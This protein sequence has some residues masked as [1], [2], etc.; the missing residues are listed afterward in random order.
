MLART[1]AALAIVAAAEAFSTPA[2]SGL[3]MSS[4]A[5]R[6]QVVQAGAAAAAVTPFIGSQPAAAKVQGPTDEFAPV[7]TVFDHRGC[8]RAPKEYSGAKSRDMEDE[9]MVKVQSL[10]IS[11][12]ESAGAAFTDEV[13]ALIR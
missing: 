1:T 6:R 11:V 9:M 12:P 8:S 3:R 10:K 13:I 2:L 5:S 4:D 7:I